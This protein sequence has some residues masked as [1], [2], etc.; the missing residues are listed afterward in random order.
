MTRL[1]VIT[2]I[3]NSV[4]AIPLKNIQTE[5]G[6][7]FYGMDQVIEALYLG[8]T[9]G[10]NVLLY[11]PGGFGK[12]QVVKAF[13][14]YVNVP[15]P[16]I[17]GYED[18][19]V[20]ALL[21]IPNIQKLTNESVYETAF[22]KS[23]F[24]SQGVLILEEFLDA[25]P[26]V[27]AALKDI[28]T[29]GGLRQ[30]NNF[31][32]SLISSVVICSNKSPEEVSVDDTTSAFYKERFPIRVK[33]VWNSYTREDYLDFLRLIKPEQSAANPLLYDVL[34]ETASRTNGLV[35]PRV[36]KDA[37]DLLDTHE[38]IRVIQYIDGL[39]TSDM[40]EVLKYCSF[41]KE[42]RKVQTILC[43]AKTWLFETGKKPMITVR[44]ITNTLAEVKYVIDKMKEV[45]S[46]HQEN[47]TD[48][49]EFIKACQEL[50][51]SLRAKIVGELSKEAE[52]SLSSI[53]DDTG[54]TEL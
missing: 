20:E 46:V 6:K 15:G 38:D 18:M 44:T 54:S 52:T 41:V 25:R 40:S 10:K 17:V 11:G 48:I 22:D 13:L 42:K 35:S 37:S 30:N 1:E 34:A 45:S 19:E 21:G 29:E 32:E 7:T 8:I 43:K 5:L 31:T 27:A 14:D 39:D 50:E 36:V 16:T 33:V 51:S 12:T 47:L 2:S 28:L 4:K 53:F 49:L 3:R 9:T 23:V 24:R 26:S